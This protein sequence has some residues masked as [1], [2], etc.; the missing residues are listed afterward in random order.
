MKKLIYIGSFSRL[1]LHAFG[2]IV[3][4]DF[5]NKKLPFIIY[6]YDEMKRQCSD[7]CAKFDYEYVDEHLYLAFIKKWRKRLQEYNQLQY[8]LKST[9]D[10]RRTPDVLKLTDDSRRTPYVIKSNG[11][12]SEKYI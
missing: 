4:E 5:I 2:N 7:V 8:V 6:D 3:N 11:Y 10:S 9:D 1:L 12:N